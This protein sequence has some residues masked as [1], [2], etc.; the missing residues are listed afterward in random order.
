MNPDIFRE[1]D[2]RGIVEDDLDHDAFL[3]IG[4][5]YGTYLEQLGIPSTVVA[6]DNRISS[7]GFTEALIQGIIST[8]IDVHAIGQAPTPIMNFAVVRLGFPA[9]I[10]VTASHNPV[11]Y[12]GCKL[13]TASRILY[14]EHIRNLKELVE[15]KRFNKGRGTVHSVNAVERYIDEVSTLIRIDPSLKVVVDA[16]NG[17]TGPIAPELLSRCGVDVV[18]L[19]CESDGRFPNHLPDPT[20][21]EYMTDLGD[22]VRN[23]SADIGIGLDG[24]GD[25]VGAVDEQG[26]IVYG[27]R[28]LALFARKVLGNRSGPVIFDAKCS[29]SLIEEIERLGGMPVIWKTGYPLIWNKMIEE[30]AQLGGEMSGH[31]YLSDEYFGYDDG[32][33]AALRILEAIISDGRSFSAIM[34]TIPSYPSTPELRLRCTEEDKFRIVDEIRSRFS[35]GFNVITVDGVR[36]QYQDGWALVRASNTQPIIVAR[37]EARDEQRLCEI[38]EEFRSILST[39]PEIKDLP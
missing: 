1:Y 37:F 7:P 35:Q 39:Y 19:Y 17:S 20:V 24:D 13:R 11:E 2:I 8:G 23:E 9:G 6:H 30:N 25:R 33:Y 21:A 18:P 15:S 12:N 10:V 29:L 28:L 14:G 36:V 27:D 32:M 4:K 5:A 16:G 38:I 3:Y 31:M 34:D 26:K 22:M